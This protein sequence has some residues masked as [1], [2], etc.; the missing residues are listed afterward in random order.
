MTRLRVKANRAVTIDTD[1]AAIASL[2]QF[3]DVAMTGQE[4][5]TDRLATTPELKI[6]AVTDRNPAA[7]EVQ[8][9]A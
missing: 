8:L 5:H 3:P 6:T 2:D 7:L 1:Q 9:C 4:W